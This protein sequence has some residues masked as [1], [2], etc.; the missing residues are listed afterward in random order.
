M[1]PPFITG[2]KN[3]RIIDIFYIPDIHMKTENVEKSIM[4]MERSQAFTN[5]DEGEQNLSVGG[6]T[7]KIS[8]KF[9]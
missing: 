1:N 3:K 7:Q 5:A 2:G 9:P 4:D 6:L 8:K